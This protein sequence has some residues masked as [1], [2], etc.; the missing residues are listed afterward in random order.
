MA[1]TPLPTTT[2]GQL[3]NDDF[4]NLYLRDNLNF[5]NGAGAVPTGLIVI[6]SGA[7]GSIPSGWAHNNAA[8]GSIVDLRNRMVVGA[9]SAYAVGAVGGAVSHSQSAHTDHVVTQPTHTAHSV[10]Q[11]DDS[12]SNYIGTGTSGAT[13]LATP[14]RAH[15]GMTVTGAHIHAGAA[16]T[17]GHTHS[18]VSL[19]PTYHALAF[20]QKS[21][22]GTSFTTAITWADGV[23]YDQDDFNA[24]LK[25]NVSHLASLICP[26][27]TILMWGG[28]LSSLPSGW[29][30][31]D[32]TNSTPDLRGKF[33][34]GA[35]D[36]YSVGD[37]GGQLTQNLGNHGSHSATQAA[38]HGSHTIGQA[39]AHATAN[40]PAGGTTL[41]P[42]P[43]SAN[44]SGANL[45]A[46]A[47]HSSFNAD[48]HTTH[49]DITTLPPYY[50][51]GFIVRTGGASITSPK[52]WA[53]GEIVQSSEFGTYLRDNLTSIYNG[54]F[55]IG[56][57]AIW[58][59]S[60]GSIPSG[61][62]LCNG[63]NSTPDLR[64]KFIIGAGGTYGVGAAGGA[65]S[66]TPAVHSD[67]VVTQPSAHSGHSVT[68]PTLHDITTA[69]NVTLTGATTD[70]HPL[71]AEGGG[72]A[73]EHTGFA[74]DS[75]AA[76]SFSVNAHAAHSAIDLRPP[77]HALAYV[78]R[79]S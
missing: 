36:T 67:H 18:V 41:F 37:T 69:N 31:C 54:Q 47:V 53:N 68:Q 11:P 65:S 27:S 33:I 16:L 20:M 66:V 72:G 2:V 23:V 63:T 5:L 22:P 40:L 48:S 42:W 32:G 14:P 26:I 49:A 77:Y 55:P 50:A 35:G 25:N 71:T 6:W 52:T 29:L 7:I 3:I 46:H 10:T 34:I 15:S 62:Q 8:G 58:S 39:T 44:H 45:G 21:A 19:L 9:G 28:S 75:H 43:T 59:G 70:P 73:R 51:L 30:L 60:T 12:H 74:V 17:G 57:I 4:L 56:G 38:D 1:W 78:Q 76:H 61:F 79:L 13:Y 64:D 24:D